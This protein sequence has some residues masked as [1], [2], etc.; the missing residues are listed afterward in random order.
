MRCLV[1]GV[2]GF[3]GSHLARRLLDEGHEVVGVDCFTDYYAREI[4]ERNLRGMAAHPRFRLV[5]TDLVSANLSHILEGIRVVFHQ[6]GQPG[7]TGSWGVQFQEYVRNNILA[8]QSLLEAVKGRPLDRFV[9]A[10]SSSVYGDVRRYPT[11]EATMPRPRSPYGV[12]KLAAEHLCQLYYRNY[13]VPVIALRYFTV[14]GPGQRPD[15]AF[16]RFIAA[17]LAGREITV[18]G[19]GEQTRDFT[20]VSDI[21][22]ANLL[23]MSSASHGVSLNIGGGTTTSV[24]QVIRLVESLC[25]RKALVRHK[26]MRPGE[27]ERTLADISRARRLLGYQPLVSLEEGLA[28]QVAEAAGTAMTPLR[29]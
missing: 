13:D 7:V 25:G 16:H 22:T 4:K 19:D 23:A 20:Y 2:A 10:S 11:S 26:P 8:T 12:T 28:R 5:E 18:Y 9:Y 29:T 15:M 3:I 24:N 21:V 17:I 27:V 1:T 14:F 6:A